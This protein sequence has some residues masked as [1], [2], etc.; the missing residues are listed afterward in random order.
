MRIVPDRAM[1]DA[2]APDREVVLVSADLHCCWQN[3]AALAAMG[4][5][6][7][8]PGLLR[9]EE[10]FEAVKRI[11]RDPEAVSNS[12]VADAAVAAARG[13]VGVVHLE[14]RWNASDWL[15]P[16]GER[17][18]VTPRRVRH[19]HRTPRAGHHGRFLERHRDR[20][21]RGAR[22][23]R[24]IQGHHRRR[25]QHAHC[26]HTYPGLDGRHD[27]HGLL[28]VEPKRLMDLLHIAT[29]A[30][31]RSAVHAIG[32]HAKALALNAFEAT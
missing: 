7:H 10:S 28:S 31:F 16:P 19:L 8:P 13:V 4:R 12:C 20:R 14:M 3:S 26:D 6:D 18:Q 24:T 27:A 22:R 9:E 11:D 21:N 2:I 15:P 1:F 32:D 23:G 25:A 30:E 29:G 5:P 17:D